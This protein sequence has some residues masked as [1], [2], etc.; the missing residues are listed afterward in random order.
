MEGST[1]AVKNR[2]CG[3]GRYRHPLTILLRN[4]CILSFVIFPR[5]ISQ[6]FEALTVENPEHLVVYDSFQQSL[7]S[8]QRTPLQP[9]APIKFLKQRDVLGDGFTPCAK[10]EVDG[11]VF[12]FLRD[13]SGQLAGW[14]SLGTTRIFHNL[15]FLNDT[16]EVLGPRVIQIQDP[17][18][19]SRRFLSIG[20]RCLRYF[21]ADGRTYIRRLGSR[22]SYGWTQLSGT[23]KGRFWQVVRAS[24]S[25]IDLSPMMRD[26]VNAKINEV[27]L[28]Y[29]QVYS[30]L[31]KET[32][33]HFPV[34]Q[35]EVHTEKATILLVLQ[36]SVAAGH[37]KKT[38]QSLAST[39]QTYLLGTEY[40]VVEQGNQIEIKKQ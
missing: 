28:A 31:A 26:R 22:P 3:G 23:D 39:L 37:Y 19:A 21:N 33:K 7:S 27:N 2:N 30:Q 29:A 10:V 12:Y 4:A 25:N 34:P 9:F 1:K 14:K 6:T 36:P 38:I 5:A 24:R 11:E 8:L 16:V 15:K 20:E 18:N 32:G 13:E 40:S 17:N 35:W